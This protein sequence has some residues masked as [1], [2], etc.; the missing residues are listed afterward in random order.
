[1]PS[2]AASPRP[3]AESEPPSQPVAIP[4]S[5]SVVSAWVSK[6]EK[7]YKGKVQYATGYEPPET[8]STGTDTTT[9]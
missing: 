6:V 3:R 9:G 1:M 4:R 7:A 2:S 5:L 8:T